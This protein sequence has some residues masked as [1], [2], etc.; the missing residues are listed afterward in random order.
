MY[1]DRAYKAAAIVNLSQIKNEENK[2]AVIDFLL[3]SGA[4][5][6]T[7]PSGLVENSIEFLSN[8]GYPKFKQFPAIL[9]TDDYLALLIKTL[10]TFNE[11]GVLRTAP[12]MFSIKKEIPD[13]KHLITNFN[14]LMLQQDTISLCNIWQMKNYFG[15]I[16][17]FTK[18]FDPA[19]EIIV[20]KLTVTPV[21]NPTYLNTKGKIQEKLD[22]LIEAINNAQTA[23]QNAEETIKNDS[24]YNVNFR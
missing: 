18:T 1:Y 7:F 16:M 13:L 22:T 11:E 14:V 3:N 23:F 12:N 4:I 2:L 21:I 20:G 24:K 15:K 9:T 5:Q 19:D 17:F 6:L 8:N 10:K